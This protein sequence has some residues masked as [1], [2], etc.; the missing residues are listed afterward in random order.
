M[1]A[2]SFLMSISKK[3]GK[4][5]KSIL[6]SGTFVTLFIL[7][8]GL[9]ALAQ[10]STNFI[11]SRKKDRHISSV[12][13]ID[14]FTTFAGIQFVNGQSADERNSLYLY[15][16]VTVNNKITAGKLL[17][18]N[19]YFTELGIKKFADSITSISEDQYNFKNALSYNLGKSK[20]AF[21]LSVASKSQYFR[22]YNYRKDSAGSLNR[23]LYTT[24]L[25]PGYVNYSGGIKYNINA[26]CSLEFGL[27]NA[28]K[29]KIRN[30]A[31]FDSRRL[32]S[33]YGLEKGVQKKTDFGFNLVF[34]AIQHKL[35]KDLYWE[36]FSQFGVNNK[37]ID[38]L[39]SYRADVN[40][41]FHYKFLKHFRFT[42]RTKFLYD[43]SVYDKP[44]LINSF[45]LGFYLNN[46]F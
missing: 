34:S 40:N 10:D 21:N 39:K 2:I 3:A 20:L 38:M 32:Q 26:Y 45:T 29:T 5:S 43:I 33:L 4:I 6:V 13:V 17:V 31:I 41:A 19:Y 23:Y 44:K 7:L 18:T 22:H 30:Q 14:F 9:A 35:L 12:T 25:S 36:N 8:S 15:Y 37:D 11:A 27:A 46:T 16:N 24:Y 42:L 28:R 1:Y